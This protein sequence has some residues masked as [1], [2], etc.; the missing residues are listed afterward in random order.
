M[1][2]NIET[3]RTL[4]QPASLSR[5]DFL[6]R[7]AVG[8]GLMV[9]FRLAGLDPVGE[10][11]AQSAGSS[12]T[13]WI[14]IGLDSTVTLQIASTEMGQGVMT[15][16]AQIVA[17]ELRFDW[18][19]IA[20]R[21]APVDAAHGGANA[22]PYGRFTGGSLGIR[23]FSPALQ[24]AAANARQ[25]LILAAANQW[26]V[27]AA[28]LTAN[29]GAVSGLVNGTMQ[30]LS[31]GALAAAAASIVLPANVALNQYPR[32]AVG[33]SVKRVDIPDKVTGA[34]K[35][36]IDVWVPGMLFA[37]VK[38]CPT[39]GGTVSSVGSKPAG[40]IAAVQVGGTATSKAT[41]VAVVAATTWDAMNAARS[42]SVNWTLPTDLPSRDSAAIAARAATLMATGTPL[43]D[44]TADAAALVAGLGAPNV[45]IN[46]TYQAPY[47]AHAPLEP[48]NCT[49][50][51]IA[52]TA[53]SAAVCNVWAPTQGP[54]ATLATARALC[55]PG[56]VVNVT[57]TLVGGGFGRKIEQDFVREAVQVGLALPGQTVK[58]TWSREQDFA[59]DQYRPMALI[60]VQAAAAPATG[61]V[62]GWRF[63]TVT[64]SI[65]VQ[66]G[67]STAKV[68]HAAVEG[69]TG[70]YAFNTAQVEWVRHDATIPV[71]YWRSVGLSMNTFAV[72]CAM[73]EL[74]AAIGWDPIQFRRANITDPRMLAVLNSVATLS[75][76]SSPPPSGRAR[77]IACGVGFNSY[78]AQ[79]AEISVNATTGAITVHRVSTAIDC[80]TAINPDLVKAQ[81][82]GAVAMGIGAALWQQ[83][84]F[85]NG[86][87]QATNYSRYKPVKIG[88]M[89]QVDVSIVNSGASLGGV[90]E[91]GLPCVAPAIANACARLLGPAARK[92]SMPF[93]PGSTLGGL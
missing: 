2:R 1:T 82:E 17:D 83:Q 46:G 58:L 76:W 16:M 22:S 79:V 65:A 66:R 80:G 56:T 28:G 11:H 6:V 54:D 51:F 61:V 47:L 41:G 24:Q 20:V 19:R 43:L 15:G 86:V 42:I 23:L 45:G 8:G 9:G 27:G 38:H 78:V 70:P 33:A 10:A 64:P 26:G 90:G 37:A 25:M 88:E 87:A 18:N 13:P 59:N 53:T 7:T 44:R 93:F 67:A 77:G 68:D 62:T 29:N 30:T 39:L 63:R 84:T 55:P 3:R 75:G 72:E 92:R 4:A 91:T 36:G 60:N 74:A 35:F 73:D 21:H 57:N 31:F 12:L 89:P 85:V 34:A 32:T 14:L 71:G 40:A 5:R 52:Q 50:Q 48:M 81:V 69:G 49:V